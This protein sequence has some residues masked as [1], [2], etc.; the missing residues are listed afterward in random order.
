MPLILPDFK[1]EP[2][3][4]CGM[5]G[6]HHGVERWTLRIDAISEKLFRPFEGIVR[7]LTPLTDSL[8]NFFGPFFVSLLVR[9]GLAVKISEPDDPA[10]ETARCMF[11][12]AKRRGIEMHEI[13]IFGLPRRQFVASFRGKSWVFEGLPRPSRKQHSI[14]WIDNKAE[15]KKRFISAGFPVARGGVCKNETQA[16]RIFRALEKPV[17]AKP[18][19]GS[20]GRHTTVFIQSVDELIRGYRSAR[21]ISPW[22]IIEEQLFGPVF[23]ATLVNRKLVAVLR[24]DPPCVTGEGRSTIRELVAIEN[25][26]PLRRGPI[27]A[28]IDVDASAAQRELKRQNVTPESIP[29]KGRAIYLH[30]KVNWGVGGT[31]RDV[32]DEV[33]PENNKLFEDIGVYLLDDIVGIDFIAEDIGKSWREQKRC[34]VIECNSLP[35][36]GNHHFPFTGPVK[37]VAGAVWDMIFPD[38]R[39]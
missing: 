30:F 36:I 34:G 24:R 31:S 25:E 16:I 39:T 26:N 32:T 38:S 21:L 37:N 29:A 22:V 2:C 12:E 13:R 4:E 1:P 28:D 27:F 23:R 14:S 33:H 5:G 8:I 11:E 7:N 10:S 6:V 17:I 3:E 35:A 18:H 19:E 20:G 9:T 15:M